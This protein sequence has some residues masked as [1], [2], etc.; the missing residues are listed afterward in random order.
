LEDE[1]FHAADFGGEQLARV[2]YHSGVSKARNLFVG[3]F[4]SSEI[5]DGLAPAGTEDDSAPGLCV[6]PNLLE[7]F[8][9]GVERERIDLCIH[10]KSLRITRFELHYKTEVL[11][12]VPVCGK[13][14]T[15]CAYAH[16]VIF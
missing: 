4:Q 11:A 3:N 15:S 10:G 9:G 13:N 5:G 1:D 7:S 12:G 8:H 2:A 6:R 14:M 16:E